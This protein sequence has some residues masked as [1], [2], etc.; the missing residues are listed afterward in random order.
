MVM[1]VIDMLD[2]WGDCPRCDAFGTDEEGAPCTLCNGAQQFFNWHEAIMW[3]WI[4]QSMELRS[5]HPPDIAA[6]MLGLL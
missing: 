2:C 1:L 3:Q 6:A 4:S 5:S